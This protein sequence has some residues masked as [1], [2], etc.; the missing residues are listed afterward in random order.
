MS[1]KVHV[2]DN[3][4]VSCGGYPNDESL[5]TAQRALEL[6]K[7]GVKEGGEI[8][9]IAGCAN[10]IGPEKSIKNFY[11]PL[12]KDIAQVL[13]EFQNKYVMYVHK[14]YKFAALIQKINRIFIYSKLAENIMTDIHLYPISDPQAIVDR[15]LLDNPETRI[16]I[17]TQG[18]KLAVYSR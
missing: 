9:F 7:N 5:Y 4:I 15:W 12:K 2:A 6:T 16:N 17:F 18:N 3:M 14:T 13:S 8:L 10:G 11:D 1:T